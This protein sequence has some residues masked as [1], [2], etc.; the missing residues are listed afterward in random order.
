VRRCHNRPGSQVDRRAQGL[1]LSRR[2]PDRGGDAHPRVQAEPAP[3]QLEEEQPLVY[4]SNAACRARS[5]WDNGIRLNQSSKQVGGDYFDVVDGEG[6]FLTAI[7]DVSGKGVPAALVM[8]MMQA[9]LRTQADEGRAVSE[10][11]ARINRLMLARGETGMFAT[12]FLGR[13]NPHTLDLVYCNAGH[14]PPILLR[15]NGSFEFL[16][17]GGLLLGVFD[18]RGW[19]RMVT[20]EPDRVKAH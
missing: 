20:L 13:L 16:H 5:L 4:R 3:R 12:C 10:I 7:A 17:H 1:F 9:S 2:S 11:L 14:N 8:S 6:G 18:A 15:A 19:R